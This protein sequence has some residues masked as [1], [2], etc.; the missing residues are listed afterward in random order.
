MGELR[1]GFAGEAAARE[2]RFFCPPLELCTDNAAMV[3]AAGYF[4]FQKSGPSPLDLPAFPRLSW[5]LQE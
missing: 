2:V 1:K 5:K 3:A 4:H